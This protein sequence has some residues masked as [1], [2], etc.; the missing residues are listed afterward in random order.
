MIVHQY[1]KEGKLDT[2]KLLSIDWTNHMI[3]LGFILGISEK[4]K[5]DP[6]VLKSISDNPRL[7]PSIRLVSIIRSLE[8]LLPELEKITDANTELQNSLI[9]KFDSISFPIS[10]LKS[11][12]GLFKDS[13]SQSFS[14]VFKSILEKCS[15][16][17][18]IATLGILAHKHSDLLKVS[19]TLTLL[20]KEE[21]E[22][23]ERHKQISASEGLVI[24]QKSC[25]IINSN[26]IPFTDSLSLLT[27]NTLISI[28]KFLTLR[29]NDLNTIDSLLI[30]FKDN[31]TPNQK[32]SL[33]IN[34]SSLCNKYGLIPSEAILKEY[35]DFKQ[36]EE[37]I[38]KNEICISS[39]KDEE[40]DRGGIQEETKGRRNDYKNNTNLKDTV[41][42]M[43]DEIY[44]WLEDCISRGITV[45]VTELADKLF[46]VFKISHKNLFDLMA[47]Y[48]RT[49]KYNQKKS[50]LWRLISKAM[51]KKNMFLKNEKNIINKNIDILVEKA[52]YNRY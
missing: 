37:E 45:D 2:E 4:I 7:N 8:S 11:N 22:K 5:I 23:I 26:K 3:D 14:Q 39:I 43:F 20:T 17:I 9:E 10:Q 16:N 31:F 29:E 46:K 52:N 42:H 1:L 24:I 12:Y 51:A 44:Y 32:Q 48:S 6:T 15:S 47:Y 35:E 30:Q 36:N 13:I 33:I 25:E 19:C 38:P 49:E 21:L 50:L 18:K 40:K 27:F 34:Y 28:I 41:S